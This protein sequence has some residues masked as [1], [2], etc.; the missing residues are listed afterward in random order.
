MHGKA[1]RPEASCYIVLSNY[2]ATMA[3]GSCEVSIDYLI[4]KPLFYERKNKII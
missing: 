4:E 1:S 3:S 2:Y